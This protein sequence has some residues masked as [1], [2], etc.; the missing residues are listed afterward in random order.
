MKED[1]PMDAKCRDKFLVQSVLVPANQDF[2]SASTPFVT[3]SID[4]LTCQQWSDIE[5]ASKSAIQEKKIRVN[6][7]PAPGQ[8][9]PDKTAAGAIAGTGAAANSTPRKSGLDIDD[10]PPA[11]SS[12]ISNAAT[13]AR[14]SGSIPSGPVSRPESRPEDARSLGDAVNAAGV[15]DSHENS[16]AAGVMGT[17]AGAA[18]G[19][20][21]KTSNLIPTSSEELKTQLDNANATILRLKEQIQDSTGLRQRKAGLDAEEKDNA[22]G[23]SVTALQQAP[24]GVP[25][26]LVAALCLV[27]FLLA[28]LL[29]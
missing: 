14:S 8:Q 28:Y 23:H 15:P 17:A 12:P 16:A 13:P 19:L 10:Q 21:S 3:C 7:L 4:G 27:S 5:S 26:P 20:A 11:Y 25:V 18:S 29:F 9:A 2:K 24:G 6:F 1:P 22:M